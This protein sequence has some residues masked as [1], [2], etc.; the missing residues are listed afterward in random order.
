MLRVLLFNTN[1]IDRTVTAQILSQGIP[2][3]QLLLAPTGEEAVQLLEQESPDLFLADIPR[4]DMVFSNMLTESRRK[5][6]Q[7][8]ILVTS[9]AT[10][11]VVSDHVWRLGLRDYLLKPFRPQWLLA[12]VNALAQPKV[13][14][15]E[16]PEVQ[17]SSAPLWKP[18]LDRVAEALETFAYKKSLNTAKEYLDF[19]DESVHT[20]GEIR[21]NAVAFAQGMVDLSQPLDQDLHWKLSEKLAYFQ[22]RFDLQSR[23][24]DTFLLYE[25]MLDSI[26]EHFESKGV[27]QLDSQQK[28]LNYIDRRIKQGISLDQAAEYSNMSACYFSKVFKRLSGVTF[29]TY[30]TDQKM[31]LAQMMLQTTDLPVINI[32]Y[33]LS[34]NETNYF[35]KAFKKKVGMSPTEY[36]ESFQ[37]SQT[38]TLCPGV[39]LSEVAEPVAL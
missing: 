1:K 4:F 11:Q 19:L 27:Y 30:V 17:A 16:V 32:A 14:T 36:R 38:V 35:S 26:F 34:Y 29:I 2:G 22:G 5:A 25:T 10:R 9:E 28:V 15:A 24:F 39:L 13:E 6:P 21:S 33:D 7:T 12:A 3:I 23:K 20:K 18:Y 37:K 8:P 31:E